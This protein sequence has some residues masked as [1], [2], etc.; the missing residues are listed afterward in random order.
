MNKNTALWM[1]II[2]AGLS[3]YDIATTP[4]GGTAGDLYGTG[5]PLASA[6]WKVYTKPATTVA[7]VTPAKDY[8]I[9]ISD[10]VAGVGAWF[11][12]FK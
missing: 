4:S 11:Y 12:F 2:G 10:A 5:K 7:P 8:Y 1:M 9:S 6:R 3:V